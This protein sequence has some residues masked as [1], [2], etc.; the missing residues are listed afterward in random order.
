M[1]RTLFC[2]GNVVVAALR[3]RIITHQRPDL[4]DGGRGEISRSFVII[5]SKGRKSEEVD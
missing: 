4:T 1:G 3:T 2:D 5:Q